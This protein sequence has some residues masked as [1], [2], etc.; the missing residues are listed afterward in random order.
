MSLLQAMARNKLKSAEKRP[1]I[2]AAC[3]KQATLW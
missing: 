3:W 1:S 2:I